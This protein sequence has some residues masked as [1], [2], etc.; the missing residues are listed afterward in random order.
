MGVKEISIGKEVLKEAIRIGAVVSKWGW[1]AKADLTKMV[2]LSARITHP[3]GN[4]RYE[5]WVFRVENG[6][7]LSVAG[8]GCAMC[9]WQ[10]VIRVYNEEGEGW[11]EVRCPACGG[12]AL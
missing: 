12:S 8:R 11:S 2:R 6:A 10:G 4:W 7:L 5:G 9:D 1:G 3:L